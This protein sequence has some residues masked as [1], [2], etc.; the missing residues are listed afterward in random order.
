MKFALIK[1]RK[2]IHEGRVLFSPLQLKEIANRYSQH[3]FIVESSST[4][5]FPDNAYTNLGLTV[6]NDIS[7]AD[8][9]LGIKEIPLKNLIPHKTY[10]FFS[11]TTKMQPHNKNYLQGLIE[12]RITFY[13]YENFTDNS[14]KRLVAFGK[15]AGNI[16]AYHAIRTYGLKNDLFNLKR[17]GAF[18]KIQELANAVSN[19][20]IPNIKIVLT[21][22]GNVGNGAASFLSS[23]GI[24][25]V[26][27]IRFL[28][29]TYSKPVFTQLKKED[30][31]KHSLSKEYNESDFIQYP[32]NYESDFLKFAK[33][34]HIF[35]A[36]HYYH[37]GMPML[38]TTTQAKQPDFKINT[39][40]DI[41]CDL[42]QPIPTC[43]RVSTPSNPIYGY[44]KN[45][46]LEINFSTP[47]SIAVMAVDNLPCELPEYS[48]TEFGKQFSE[49]ILPM[50]TNNFNDPVLEKA[51]VL[52]H[53]KITTRYQYLESFISL[54]RD[55][56]YI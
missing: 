25:Q 28:S 49:K 40:A 35:I 21:G 23:I 26:S 7:N 55:L 16:G 53:G 51:C 41:S 12:K 37:K 29:T 42:H 44:D 54:E 43:L 56:S 4:R 14:N 17:P 50:L 8:V 52:K 48:S 27:P 9:F 13:D 31:L 30:Y 19:Y 46:G 36:G 3:Q 47:N 5:C 11:H 22:T 18:S 33:Q 15:S 38:F 20:S 10:F 32:Y 34:A 24:Q 45:N 6:T 39:I 2:S 1:E